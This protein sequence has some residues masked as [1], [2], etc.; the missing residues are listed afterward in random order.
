MIGGFRD[1]I[2][3]GNLIDLAVAVIIGLAFAAVINSLV[4]DVFTPLIAAI[5]GEP[6]FSG[7]TLEI[8][9]G[10]IKYGSFLNALITFLLTAAA[11]YF[12]I[13]LPYNQVVERR[14]RGEAPADPMTRA[15]PECLSTIPI[16]ARRCA[17]CASPVSA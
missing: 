13:V 6:D 5:V 15:C 7:L 12:F 17:F 8:G 1:F 9:D 11:V 4:S 16:A 3:R 14:R 10:V 2:M